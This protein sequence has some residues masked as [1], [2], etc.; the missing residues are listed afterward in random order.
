MIKLLLKL[1]PIISVLLIGS[2]FSRIANS[3]SLP[4]LAIYLAKQTDLTPLMIGV[5]IGA[6]PLASTLSGILGGY[7]SD[8][9][10]RKQIMLL[11]IYSWGF[12][13]IGFALA[14]DPII[15][16]LLSILNGICKAFF[17]PVSQ[18]LMGD[19]T[20]QKLRAKVFSLR[21]T[22]I[23]AGV[24]IGPLLGVFIGLSSSGIGFMITGLFYF[25]YSI[26]LHL[27]TSKV[28]I[29]VQKNKTVYSM[30]QSLIIIKRDKVLMYFILGACITQIGFAQFAPLSHH[31]STTFEKGV[32]YFGWMM[33]TNALV[34][35]LAQLPL[36]SIFER[37]S[38]ITGVY[39]G[40]GLY[41]IGGLGFA[42]SNSLTEMILSMI[43]FTL[44]EVLCF[45]AG[46][47]LI[48]NLAPDHLRGSYYG[49]MNF[50][51]LGRFLGPT[52]G[53]FLYSTLNISWLF[54][55]IFILLLVSNCIYMVGNRLWEKQSKQDSLSEENPLTPYNKIGTV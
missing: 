13:F 2:L 31:M 11:S 21:Y 50:T 3:M 29:P 19:L 15:F 36:S 4:F 30:K 43:I 18:A 10:G 35:V 28:S 8:K 22:V 48:D 27:F 33:T 37:F 38:T 6:A 12:V 41:A 46:T 49:A 44:G 9:F 34:V 53:M 32:I 14:K 17:E 40:N 51:E 42:F 26:V 45:P 16:L 25:V 23:N 20:E 7:L 24:A 1:H 5:V 47:I 39:V 55:I 52:L 54:S